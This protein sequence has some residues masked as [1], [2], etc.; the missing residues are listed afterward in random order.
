MDV[1]EYIYGVGKVKP[2]GKL[3]GRLRIK[4]TPQM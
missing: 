1:S 4:I 2:G 3:S